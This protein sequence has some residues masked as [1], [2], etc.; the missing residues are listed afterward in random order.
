MRHVQLDG[1]LRRGN[2]TALC[3]AVIP[4]QPVGEYLAATQEGRAGTCPECATREAARRLGA[5]FR[6]CGACEAAGCP[7]CGGRGVF[8]WLPLDGPVA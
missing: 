1:D 5:R 2:L 8:Q 6:A 7:A 4:I 3:G